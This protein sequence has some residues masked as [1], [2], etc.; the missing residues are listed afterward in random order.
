M[1]IHKIGSDLVRPVRSTGPDSVDGKAQERAGDGSKR[2]GRVDRVGFSEEGLALA[3]LVRHVETELTPARLAEIEAR[4]A[5]GFY[6]QPDVAEEVAR[7]LL[8]SG[9]L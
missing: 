3:K 7:R 4:I 8:L 9:D 2:S 5:N 1:S 6:D